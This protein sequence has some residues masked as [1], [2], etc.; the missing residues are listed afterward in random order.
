MGLDF[1]DLGVEFSTP[2]VA[3]AQASMTLYGLPGARK[4]TL[5]ASAVEVPELSPVLYLDL[6]N[7]TAAVAAKYANRD[8][9]KVVQLRDWTTAAG[10]LKRVVEMRHEYKTVVIDPINSLADLL[11]LHMISRV[12]E[13]RQLM[14]EKDT[15]RL[16]SQEEQR[17]QELSAV[18]MQESTNNSLGEATTSLA[19]YGIVGTKMMEIISTFAAAEFFAIFVTHA[20]EKIDERTKRAVMRPDMAGNVGSRQ[21]RQRPHVVAYSELN[22]N[23]DGGK[24]QLL[25]FS[26]E[27]GE[28]NDRIPFEAKERLGGLLGPGMKNPTMEKIWNKVKGA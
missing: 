22:D 15:R 27:H 23:D 3:L 24:D 13:K 6:E 25:Y 18:K 26:G 4:T 14:Q 5:A 7:S 2:S 11:Q 17:L 21:L 16:T 1:S 9:L 10:V 28:S 20:A 12:E 19:D 8:D